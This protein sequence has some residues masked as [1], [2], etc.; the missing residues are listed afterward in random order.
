MRFMRALADQNRIFR[1]ALSLLVLC[2]VFAMPVL[3]P[4]CAQADALDTGRYS[5][6]QISF[7]HSGNPVVGSTF[8]LYRVAKMND[9]LEFTPYAPFDSM[10][11]DFDDLETAADWDELAERL[12][13]EIASDSSIKPLLTVK[14]DSKGE[15]PWI[16]NMKGLYLI[17]GTPGTSGTLRYEPKPAMVTFPLRLDMERGDWDYEFTVYPKPAPLPTPSPTP[18]ATPKPT[19]TRTPSSSLPQTGVNWWPVWLMGGM[20]IVLFLLGWIRRRLSED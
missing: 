8:K 16:K 14:T 5:R 6:F 15:T 10:G 19:P 18:S 12:E 2:A 13:M 9:D 20:G 17:L 1:R 3:A 11:I 7:Q 4:L